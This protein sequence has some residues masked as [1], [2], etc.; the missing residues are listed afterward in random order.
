M[1]SYDNY[2]GEQGPYYR[3]R[4]SSELCEKI[5]PPTA[6]WLATE[7]ASFSDETD[8]QSGS[9]IL[10]NG[11]GC[12]QLVRYRT[13]RR[14]LNLHVVGLRRSKTSLGDDA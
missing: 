13:N 7:S 6:P 5:S 11:L 4:S 9:W 10:L 8:Y 2:R 14:A 1:A 12:S 3:K